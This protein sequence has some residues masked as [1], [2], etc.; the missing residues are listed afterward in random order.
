MQSAARFWPVEMARL[1]IEH[2]FD[3]ESQAGVEALRHANDDNGIRHRRTT[4]I[5]TEC[6]KQDDIYVSIKPS[7]MYT[8]RCKILCG[9]C[10]RQHLYTHR[11]KIYVWAPF[12]TSDAYSP[13]LDM[14]P[15]LSTA[16]CLAMLLLSV[17]FC[18]SSF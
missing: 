14:L 16:R 12:S 5:P 13:F 15:Q 8:H 2:R 9:H 18:C 10:S 3:L 17:A 6:N 1:F 11:C 4:C 7:S